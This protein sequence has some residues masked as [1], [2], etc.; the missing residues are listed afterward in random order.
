[1]FRDLEEGKREYKNLNNLKTNKTL[2]DVKAGA[3]AQGYEVKDAATHDKYGSH[4]TMDVI[5]R[6]TG[7]RVK[8]AKDRGSIGGKKVGKGGQVD[9]TI[10]N[11]VASAIKGD[12]RARGRQDKRPQAVADR[13]ERMKSDLAKKQAR[14]AAPFGKKADGT[15]PKKR[16]FE[17]FM[18]ECVQNESGVDF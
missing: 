2:D 16:T 9:T 18:Y 17:S 4:S 5:H 14:R 10:V 11:T 12:M 8:P 7:E 13:K 1:M 3:Y 15:G 6:K